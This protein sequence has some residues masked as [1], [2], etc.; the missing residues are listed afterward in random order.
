MHAGRHIDKAA[1][2]PDGAVERG[3]LVVSGRDDGGE[4]LL[5][6]ILVLAQAAVH[7]EEDDAQL[8]PL[9]LQA[10]V[11]DF[12]LILGADPGQKLTLR[13]R[14][15]K[16]VE[17]ALDVLRHVV[18]AFALFLGRT[19]IVENVVKVDAAQ[20]GAPGRHRL[21][22]E[23]I[24]RLV[25]ELAHPIRFILDIRDLID[26]LMRHAFLGLE[27]RLLFI[28]KTVLILFLDAFKM[29]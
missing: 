12:G 13:F 19:Q 18:P 9:F 2:A 16:P 25:P 11:D 7:I 21:G 27:N 14:N 10:V 3:E 8:L 17:G 22:E 5:D 6:D 23:Y 28:V 24:Q 20:V 4:I 15:A 1:A 26:H 29:L